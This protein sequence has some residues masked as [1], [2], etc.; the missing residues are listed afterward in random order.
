MYPRKND[1]R[2]GAQAVCDDWG[3]GGELTTVGG[4]RWRELATVGE[5]WQLTVSDC[6]RQSWLDMISNYIQIP[7]HCNR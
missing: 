2:E 1:R 6:W 5:G 4:N 7:F 3:G